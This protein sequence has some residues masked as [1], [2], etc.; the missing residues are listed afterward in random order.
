M[1][2]IILP[3]FNE[4]ENLER[5]VAAL[6]RV[7]ARHGLDGRILIVDD[8][9]PD[10]T[11]AI[12][13]RLARDHDN[14]SVLHRREKQGL[15][16]AY[17]AGFR[18]A[19]ESDTRL[20]FEMDCDFSHNPEYV[21]RMLQAA[22]E[23]DLVLGSRYVPGGGVEDWGLLRRMISR[24]GGLYAKW[25][26]G[27]PVNDLTGGFK[28]FRREVL[29]ELDLDS[30]SSHGYGFQIEVTYKALKKGFRVKEVPITFS[31]RQQGQSKMSKR[32]VFEAMA[33]V[34]RLRLGGR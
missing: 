30:V 19:L 27:V 10:G 28:C 13:D 25:I 3:T 11:G 5:F 23:A 8:S 32:I 34:W 29:E 4:R 24:G 6:Q 1:F 20:I 12:A 33:Q 17:I 31:D 26:L 2:T 7:F 21:P 9:S 14:I 15:G 16:P 22:D 18:K